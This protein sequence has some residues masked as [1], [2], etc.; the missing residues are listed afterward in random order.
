MYVGPSVFFSRYSV[1]VAIS[2]FVGAFSGGGAYVTRSALIRYVVLL[3]SI[4]YVRSS[5]RIT[6]N[7]PSAGD[8]SFPVF[9]SP[10]IG[11]M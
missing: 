8:C 11:S 3:R 6:R 5:F 4:M 9:E 7:G 2:S 1:V 10:S